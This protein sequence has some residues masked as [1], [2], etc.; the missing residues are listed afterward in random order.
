LIFIS[1][2]LLLLLFGCKGYKEIIFDPSKLKV[3]NTAWDEQ[4]NETY[5]KYEAPSVKD[6][7]EALPFIIKLPKTIPFETDGFKPAIIEDL[8]NDGKKLLVTFRAYSKEEN[9]DHPIILKIIVYNFNISP[10]QP[11]YYDE[12]KLKNGVVGKYSPSNLYFQI[13]DI[14]YHIH[15]FGL[16]NDDNYPNVLFNIANQMM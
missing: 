2:L 14:E 5:I 10:P 6:G 1:V 13:D 12:V 8:E 9:P 3:I 4:G 16:P 7:I 11:K 15:I